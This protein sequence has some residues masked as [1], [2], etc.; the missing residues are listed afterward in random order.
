[1][2]EVKE[3]QNK[4]YDFLVL[5]GCGGS[6]EEWIIGITNM[7]KE[8]N[9]VSDN[10]QF[11][12]VY[13]FEYDGITNLAFALN[14]KD[15]DIGKLAIFRLKIRNKFGAMWLSDYIDNKLVKEIEI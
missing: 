15:I 14:S 12:E 10:F 7:L 13:S 1:M 4:K 2:L 3:L 5:Q 6:F 11:D 9:I 8:N